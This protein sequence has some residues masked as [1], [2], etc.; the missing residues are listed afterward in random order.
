V[1]VNEI[2]C[3]S[4]CRDVPGTTCSTDA[5]VCGQLYVPAESGTYEKKISPLL[6]FGSPTNRS[7]P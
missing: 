6:E 7:V 4:S 5:A 3:C 2:M 1:L